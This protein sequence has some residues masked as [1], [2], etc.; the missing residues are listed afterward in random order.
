M[1]DKFCYSLVAFLHAKSF[2]KGSQEEQIL[3]FKVD[4]FSEGKEK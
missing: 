3:S 2:L 1:E 4:L